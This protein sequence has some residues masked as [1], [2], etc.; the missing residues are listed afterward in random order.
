[1]QFDMTSLPAQ[2]NYKLL[3]ATV[4]PR[5]I[6]WV[7]TRSAAGIDNAAPY[8]FFNVMGHEPPTVVIGVLRHPERVHKDTSQN[9][10]SQKEFVVHLVSSQLIHAMSKTSESLPPDEDELR[11]AGIEVVE[12]D[13][14]RASRIVAAPVAFECVSTHCIETG[15]GQFVVIG[16]ALRAHI[17]DR[18]VIDAERAYIDTPALDL[19]SRMHG[20]GWYGKFPEFIELERPQSAKVDAT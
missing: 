17:D 1:M 6:A 5:P 3:T 19:V 4:V 15:P 11:H 16:R 20:S 14:V 13:A 12:A 2:I 7:T 9:I 8:S 18:L 10:L